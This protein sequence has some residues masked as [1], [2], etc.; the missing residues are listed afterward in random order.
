MYCANVLGIP[1][2]HVRVYQGDVGGGF[3]QK[4]FVG[5]DG[6][7]VILACRR[8]GRPVKWIEDRWENLVAANH[9]ARRG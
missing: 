1:E 8:L 7:A 5:R 6:T 2:T 9:A 4:F 3:G